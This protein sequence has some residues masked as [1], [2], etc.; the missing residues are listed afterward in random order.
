M[1][2]IKQYPATLLT[3]ENKKNNTKANMANSIKL[4]VENN[5]LGKYTNKGHQI[6][7]SNT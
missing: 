6:I 4:M 3:G 2:G 5:L 7:T 1:Y